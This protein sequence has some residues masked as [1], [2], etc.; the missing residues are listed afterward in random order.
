MAAAVEAKEQAHVQEMNDLERKFL[1]DKGNLQKVPEETAQYRKKGT[2]LLQISGP[3]AKEVILAALPQLQRM[4]SSD[5]EIVPRL[6]PVY[7]TLSIQC[8]VRNLTP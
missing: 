6:W 2:V 8:H 5:D 3:T 1:T 7:C 4:L